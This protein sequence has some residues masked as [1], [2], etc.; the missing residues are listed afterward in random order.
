MSSF[1]KD[2]MRV[3]SWE[4][5]EKFVRASPSGASKI[6]YVTL[7][8]DG[9]CNFNLKRVL[10]VNA[11]AK[12]TSAAVTA[13]QGNVRVTCVPIDLSRDPR[14]YEADGTSLREAY[15]RILMGQ[16][17]GAI[18]TKQAAIA[19][20]RR[21]G[22]PSCY[23]TSNGYWSS[24]LS[25]IQQCI[26]EAR[27]SESS[28]ALPEAVTL[29]AAP[30]VAPPVSP[31]VAPPVAQPVA[32]PVAQPV[33]PPLAST[34]AALPDKLKVNMKN[35]FAPPSRVEQL[36]RTC[37]LNDELKAHLKS[38]G[39]LHRAKPGMKEIIRRFFI[40]NPTRLDGTGLGVN[41]FQVDH[42]VAKNEEGLDH[43]CNF[44]LVEPS[45]NAHFGDRWN[46]EKKAFVGTHA[47]KIALA[48]HAFFKRNQYEFDFTAFDPT[49]CL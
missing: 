25:T 8:R 9:S 24:C 28:H 3:V 12:G 39:V 32:P 16:H 44:F 49:R 46:E 6:K 45:V 13:F 19:E 43:F 37:A 21:D 38:K 23:E 15:V 29:Q 7:F 17:N 18:R 10:E 14:N 22:T 2:N 48:L 47:T 4:E 33:A 36:A 1:N 11:D 31:S 27:H 35:R 42:I 41:A 5:V 20:V 30:A 34:L 40:D 26:D